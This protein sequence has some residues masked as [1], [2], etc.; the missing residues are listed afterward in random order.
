M[1]RK[2]FT[3][4]SAISLLLSL[5]AGWFAVFLG[6]RGYFY[7]DLCGAGVRAQ[8]FAGSEAMDADV[9]H[10]WPGRASVRVLRGREAAAAWSATE[11][12]QRSTDLPWQSAG[13]KGLRGPTAILLRPDGSPEE[14]PDAAL[15][16]PPGTWFSGKHWQV[17]RAPTWLPF[18]LTVLLPFAWTLQRTG[19]A[20][21]RYRQRRRP[22]R[23]L[24]PICGY[25]LRATPDRCPECGR[26]T[27]KPAAA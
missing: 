1:R 17:T 9:F 19:A 2:L 20:I 27:V 21:R 15:P 3:L 5:P 14:D 25:D 4:C 24:C 18:A 12:L 8:V 7:L 16:A 13:L 11:R 26:D 10:R 6:G 23:S 22:P